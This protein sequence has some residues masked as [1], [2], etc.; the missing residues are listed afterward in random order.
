M[1]KGYGKGTG[2]RLVT[3]LS[4]HRKYYAFTILLFKWC[5]RRTV[6]SPC[7]IASLKRKHE[8]DPE[9]IVSCDVCIAHSC[10]VCI[11]H[12][13]DV[14]IIHSPIYSCH[15]TQRNA[16]LIVPPT[17]HADSHCSAHPSNPGCAVLYHL[18]PSRRTLPM[19]HWL[20]RESDRCAMWAM[21]ARSGSRA[22]IRASIGASITAS[23]RASIRGT[24]L[25]FREF[26]RSAM[27]ARN[28]FP[29]SI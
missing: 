29:V 10:G 17:C 22:S 20:C 12:S 28:N 15:H 18:Q 16:S 4:F 14:C 1:S 25:R 27:W 5:C 3:V 21:W 24:Q 7:T 9:R 11:A 6:S 23:I 19:A 8:C 26:V 2:H 13:C